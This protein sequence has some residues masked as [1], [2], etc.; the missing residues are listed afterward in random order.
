MRKR[1][2]TV[3]SLIFLNFIPFYPYLL[4]NTLVFNWE[5]A[6]HSNILA[7]NIP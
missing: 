2:F 6:T 3:Y 1:L 5:M 4:L 7:W